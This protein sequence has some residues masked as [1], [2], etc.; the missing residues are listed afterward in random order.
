MAF[1]PGTPMTID[2]RSADR[3][4]RRRRDNVRSAGLATARLAGTAALG[5]AAAY[6]LD[7]D[8]GRARRARSR[9]QAI[10]AIRRPAARAARQAAN[11]RVYLRGRAVGAVRRVTA[12]PLPPG[13]DRTLA[14]KVRSEVLGAS[15]FSRRAINLDAVN[16]VVALRG[17][18]DHPED[19]RDVVAAVEKVPGVRRVDNLLHLPKTAPPNVKDVQRP[20]S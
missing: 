8:R 19:I 15:R 14:D 10:A 4:R 11:K 1:I 12:T 20:G 13:D 3:R 9:D 16:G 17:E 5:A 2:F 7:P 6:L 18:L